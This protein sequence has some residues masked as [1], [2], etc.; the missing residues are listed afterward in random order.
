MA[1]DRVEQLL[2]KLTQSLNAGG[3]DYAIIGDGAV[4]AWVAS[5]DESAVR[6]TKDVDLLIRLEEIEAAGEV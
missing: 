5:V 6:A 1:V 3:L 2:V 4:A